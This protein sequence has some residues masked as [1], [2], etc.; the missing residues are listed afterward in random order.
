MMLGWNIGIYRLKKGEVP[1]TA[2]SPQGMRLAVWQTGVR[3]LDWIDTLVEEGKAINLGGDGYPCRYTATAEHLIPHF[4]TG[5]PEAHSTWSF[6]AS[7]IR[8]EGW[9]GKTVIDQTAIAACRPDE[10]LLVVAWD[11]S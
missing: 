5:V 4:V 3:G 1:A 10:W 2:T 7:D 11:E 8:M 6:D 9:E